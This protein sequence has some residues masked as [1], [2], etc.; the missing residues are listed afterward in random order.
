MVTTDF[1]EIHLMCSHNFG[2]GSGV[3]QED[4]EGCKG[5]FL[6]LFHSKRLYYIN[7]SAAY[8]LKLPPRKRYRK[9]VKFQD[10]LF[11]KGFLHYKKVFYNGWDAEHHLCRPNTTVTHF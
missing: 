1:S 4:G 2:L 7:L 5:A 11:D 8:K 6:L 9:L 3:G 10:V